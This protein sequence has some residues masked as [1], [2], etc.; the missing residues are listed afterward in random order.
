M[1]FRFSCS[2]CCFCFYRFGCG[3]LRVS[4]EEPKWK[5]FLKIVENSSC[6]F[7]FLMCLRGW[8]TFWWAPNGSIHRLQFYLLAITQCVVCTLVF[9]VNRLKCD[10]G[11]RVHICERVNFDWNVF[12]G[13][14]RWY[15]DCLDPDSNFIFF[16]YISSS[17][18]QAMLC[19]LMIL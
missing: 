9:I 1:S 7:S 11:A 5:K 13:Y 6:R 8:P 17:P 2:D 10:M 18:L 19:E 4:P 3:R 12:F 16:L 15:I 14:K